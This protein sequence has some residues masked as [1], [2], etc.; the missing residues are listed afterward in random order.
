MG[1]RTDQLIATARDLLD[2]NGLEGLTIRA[3]LARSGLARR[4]FYERFGTKDDLV[5]AVFERSLAE[6]AQHF[7]AQ[8]MGATSPLER[9]R[10]I[11]VGI[12]M[13]R[14]LVAVDG[15]WESSRRSAALSREHLR[16][17]E[18][19]PMELQRAIRPMIDVIARHL[20]E[21]MATGTVRSA[22][23][24]RLA[25]LVYNLVSTTAHSVLLAEEGAQPDRRQREALAQEVWEFCLRAIAV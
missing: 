18:A 17:A 23:P 22:E 12:V 9:L 2:E 25:S 5:L 16:L 6:A 7:D 20:G 1:E 11:V 13:G 24:Q 14:A 8:G 19:R 10:M 3:V 4:A 15:Q 21:G